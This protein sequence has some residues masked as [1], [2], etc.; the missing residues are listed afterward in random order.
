MQG[1]APAQMM[2]ALASVRLKHGQKEYLVKW[3]PSQRVGWVAL[4]DLLGGDEAAMDMWQE[5]E[6]RCQKLELHIEKAKGG[7]FG[8]E[9][10]GNCI[11]ALKPGGAGEVGGLQ[12]RDVVVGLD[13]K[14]LHDTT[15]AEQLAEHPTNTLDISVVR[16]GEPVLSAAFLALMNAPK[17]KE[18]RKQEEKEAKE[19]AK[20]AKKQAKADKAAAKQAAKDAKKAAKLAKKKGGAA[21]AATLDVPS[22]D[23]EEEEE[24]EAAEAAP[25]PKPPPP[26]APAEPEPAEEE[27]ALNAED[28]F[29]AALNKKIMLGGPGPR[30]PRGSKPD[31]AAAE[32]GEKKPKAPAHTAEQDALAKALHAKLALNES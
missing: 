7:G 21:P 12:T 18:Q 23:E 32:G 27:P 30:P 14:V 1:L 6:A 5:F 9:L 22:E 16:P 28:A 2:A 20:L 26:A 8:I 13:G 3:A 25:A 17:T 24:E 10:S 15:I 4:T 11:V 19:R 31:E 29:K